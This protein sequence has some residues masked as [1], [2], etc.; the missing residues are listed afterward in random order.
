MFNKQEDEQ[1]LSLEAVVSSVCTDCQERHLKCSGGPRCKRCV[2][3]DRECVFRPTHRGRRRHVSSVTVHDLESRDS[4]ELSTTC[5]GCRVRHVKCSGGTTCHRCVKAGITCQF[6]PNRRGQRPHATHTRK[7]KLDSRQV[8]LAQAFERRPQSGDQIDTAGQ[9]AVLWLPPALINFPE[10]TNLTA[11]RSYRYFQDWTSPDLVSGEHDSAFWKALVLQVAYTEPA[12]R[13]SIAALGSLHE[14]LDFAYSAPGVNGGRSLRIQAFNHH[15]QALSILKDQDQRL[16]KEIILISCVLFV[17]FLVIQRDFQSAVNML[18]SGWKAVTQPPRPGELS[19]AAR[20][21]DLGL[22]LSRVTRQL[23]HFVDSE[24]MVRRSPQTLSYPTFDPACLYQLPPV[25]LPSNF[26]NLQHARDYLKNI[27]DYL[28][29][30]VDPVFYTPDEEFAAKFTYGV[31]SMLEQWHKMFYAIFCNNKLSQKGVLVLTLQHHMASVAALTFVPG[32]EVAFDEHNEQFEA[33]ISLS[34]AILEMGDTEHSTESYTPEPVTTGFGVIPALSF[35]AF[36]C[37]CPRLRRRAMKIL[38]NQCWVEG[39]HHSRGAAFLAERVIT[40]EEKGLHQVNTCQD[41]PP[42]HRIRLLT[43]DRLTGVSSPSDYRGPFPY[44]P[45]I[46]SVPR[47][48]EYLQHVK[49]SGQILLRYVGEPWNDSSAI[50]E[51]KVELPEKPS[52][53]HL[54]SCYACRWGTNLTMFRRNIKMKS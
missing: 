33:I 28:Y 38:Q 17:S 29:A 40:L 9:K 48:R 1:S 16:S 24:A 52:K 26:T 21:S 10:S 47:A 53:S 35:C 34:E 6:P 15:Q 13:H 43:V 7:R 3:E 32:N 5:I 49:G 51:M 44:E 4:H 25:K 22:V 39:H 31:K 42:S 12:I 18:R 23:S 27:L 50:K 46:W 37:R 19:M 45:G 54:A 14:S 41:V 20:Q 30:V 36:R 11:L 2:S 8:P